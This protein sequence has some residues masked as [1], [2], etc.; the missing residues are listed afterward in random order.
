MPNDNRRSTI[1]TEQRKNSFVSITRQKQLQRTTRNKHSRRQ[2]PGKLRKQPGHIAVGQT[3]EDVLLLR[4]FPLSPPES[5]CNPQC[6]RFYQC[7]CR[8]RVD[9]RVFGVN[10]HPPSSGNKQQ[11]RR[12]TKLVNFKK[13][14]LSGA[15]LNQKKRACNGIGELQRTMVR[16][17]VNTAHVR[18]TA[19]VYLENVL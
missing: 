8:S 4:V 7:P 12:P 19:P 11:L 9:W 1:R 18:R 13:E 5:T 10:P 3:R 15:A 2:P 17:D 6:R 14:N 16:D